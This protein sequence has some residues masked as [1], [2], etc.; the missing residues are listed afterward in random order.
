[1]VKTANSWQN[2]KKMSGNSEKLIGVCDSRGGEQY[3]SQTRGLLL[4]HEN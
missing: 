4:A 2:V 3:I 1:M